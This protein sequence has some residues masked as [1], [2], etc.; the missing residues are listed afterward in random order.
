M[1]QL[2][3]L[4]S[5]IRTLEDEGECYCDGTPGDEY[6]CP[7]HRIESMIQGMQWRMRKREVEN[8]DYK[9][10]SQGQG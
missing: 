3:K 1:N 8:E 6:T 9:A 10:P 4:L 7:I 5:F 2:N